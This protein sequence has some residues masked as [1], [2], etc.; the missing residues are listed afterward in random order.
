MRRRERVPS[1]PMDP[2]TAGRRDLTVIAVLVVALSRAADGPL[3]WLLGALLFGA[4]AVGWLQVL[5][6]GEPRGVPVESLLLPG[7]AALAGLGGVR[8]VPLGPALIP[9]VAVFGILLDRSLALEARLARQATGPSDDDRT[10]LLVLSLVTAFVGF[11][12]AAAMVPGGLADPAAGSTVDSTGLAALAV[13]DAVLAGLLGYRISAL[14]HPTIRRAL[15]A[16]I[17]TALVVAIAAG[18]LRALAVPRLIGPAALTVVLFLWTSIQTARP[19]ARR[20]PRWIWELVLLAIL[21]AIV[22]AL[23]LRLGG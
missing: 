17:T 18:A 22:V 2:R 19:S 1:A 11:A 12:G 7:A 20:D 21:G 6:D 10:E 14:G 15:V 5:G 4:V 13:A 9:A 23:N 16:A 3:L 8:L